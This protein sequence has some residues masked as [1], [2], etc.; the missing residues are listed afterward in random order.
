MSQ[1]EVARCPVP[2]QDPESRTESPSHPLL[3]FRTTLIFLFPRSLY[4]FIFCTHPFFFGHNRECMLS[5]LSGL[6]IDS[7]MGI[8][9]RQ[10][11]RDVGHPSQTK[12]SLFADFNLWESLLLTQWAP[13]II[14]RQGSAVQQAGLAWEQPESRTDVQMQGT[15]CLV[16]A[17]CS[18]SLL[19][20]PSFT[21]HS[22]IDSRV[23]VMKMM[24]NQYMKNQ[25]KETQ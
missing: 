25:Y 23:R 22:E 17:T 16:C 5:K 13:Q 1:R 2:N 18:R 20:S 24:K 4:A 19:A 11:G 21:S 12:D 6:T 8:K 15:K 7:E 3:D 14:G 10:M 9:C